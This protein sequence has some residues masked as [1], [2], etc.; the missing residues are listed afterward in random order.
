[1]DEKCLENIIEGVQALNEYS[2]F[3]FYS[4]ERFHNLIK[5]GAVNMATRDPKQPVLFDLENGDSVALI[6]WQ[7]VVSKFNDILNP[8]NSDLEE[9]NKDLNRC[10]EKIHEWVE[11]QNQ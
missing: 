9:I 5:K 4:V 3:V 7:Y 8:I 11:E 6:P 10:A 2:F 1:M